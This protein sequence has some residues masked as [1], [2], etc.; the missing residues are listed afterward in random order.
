MTNS[1]SLLAIA[2]RLAALDVVGSNLALAHVFKFL[3]HIFK[4]LGLLS[5]PAEVGL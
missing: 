3:G 2:D 4:F 1:D 5:L